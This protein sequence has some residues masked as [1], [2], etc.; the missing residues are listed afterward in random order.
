MAD[1][2]SAFLDELRGAPSDPLSRAS[3]ELDGGPGRGPPVHRSERD[4]R[5]FIACLDLPVRLDLDVLPGREAPLQ[6]LGSVLA[7]NATPIHDGDAITQ[8]VRLVHGVRGQDDR[9]TGIAGLELSQHFPDRA[10]TLRIEPG[11]RFV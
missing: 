3:L 1:L 7:E 2:V 5:F 4:D 6:R 8:V 9:E 10:A 11:R